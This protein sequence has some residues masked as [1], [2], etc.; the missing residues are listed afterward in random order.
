M[1]NRQ[2]GSILSGSP[3]MQD[4]REFA[5]SAAKFGG[6]PVMVEAP[7]GVSVTFRAAVIDAATAGWF[8]VWRI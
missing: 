2:S 4:L 5:N 7:F 1:T 3:S 6:M 8:N